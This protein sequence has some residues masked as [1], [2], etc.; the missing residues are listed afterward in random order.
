M[1][2][3]SI[4]DR[5]KSIFLDYID[6]YD[7]G[8]VIA[9]LPT[10]IGKTYS[11]CQTIADYVLNIIRQREKTDEEVHA[12]KIVWVTTLIKILPEEDL[13]KA[14][15]KR[16]LSYDD[17]VIR[18]KS[19]VD[20]ITEAIN[21]W[22]ELKNEIPE[23]V[24]H[25][26]EVRDITSLVREI[27][28]L[29]DKSSTEARQLLIHKQNELANSESSFRG[30]IHNHLAKV[31][32]AN[33]ISIED[34]VYEHKEYDWVSKIYPHVRENNYIV[35]LMTDK[36]LVLS[37]NRIIRKIPYLSKEWLKNA[38]VFIDESDATKTDVT[39]TVVDNI[40]K[41]MEG[42]ETIDF[43]KLFLMVY[44]GLNQLDSFDSYLKSFVNNKTR[45]E[46]IQEAK[47]LLQKYKMQ[48]SFKSSEGQIDRKDFLY[49]CAEWKT[50]HKDRNGSS[51][52]AIPD[53]SSNRVCLNYGKKEDYQ[54][55]EH[56]SFLV[57]KMLNDIN[58]FLRKFV[59]YVNDCAINYQRKRNGSLEVG[60]SELSQEE[61]LKTILYKYNGLEGD[62]LEL[63]LFFYS[64]RDISMVA[65]KYNLPYSFY[66]YGATW[67]SLVN[68]TYHEADTIIQMGRITETAEN[69]MSFL[70]QNALVIAMSATAN[71][72]TI[73]GNY[74]LS[75]LEN[76]LKYEDEQGRFI[77]DFHNILIE[78]PDLGKAIKEEL[79]YRYN[80][81]HIEDEKQ[82]IRIEPPIILNHIYD[83]EGRDFEE[84]F[85][86]ILPDNLSPDSK[87][88]KKIG[89][90]I[91]EAV[92]K[93]PFMD[94]GQ[95]SYNYFLSRYLN[96]LRVMLS[97]AV[98][99]NHQSC[100]CVDMA[101][102][103]EDGSTLQKKTLEDL[104]SVVNKYCKKH[105]KDWSDENC[106]EKHD[107]NIH[108]FIINSRDFF[109]QKDE[110]NNKLKNGQRLFIVSTF[111][112]V[113]AGINLHHPICE[114][115][116]P[117][118]RR[119]DAHEKR[120]D[121]KKDIDELAILD[122]TN[123]VV[124]LTKWDEFGWKEQIKNIIQI[125]E[126]YENGF[127]TDKER[128]K[129]INA[130]FNAIDGYGLHWNKNII[131]A[132]RQEA[133][134][135]AYWLV[136]V[137][138]RTKRTLWRNHVQTIYIDEKVFHSFDL[139]YQ[140]QMKDFHSEELRVILDFRE[141]WEKE[142]ERT[143]VTP[144]RPDEQ[145]LLAQ[146]KSDR[147]RQEIHRMI[148]AIDLDAG[149]VRWRPKDATNWPIMRMKAAR[150][151]IVSDE[152]YKED[153]FYSDFYIDFPD[154]NKRSSYYY[155]QKNDYDS[156]YVG[157]DHSKD[158]FSKKMEKIFKDG[159]SPFDIREV[160]EERSRLPILMKYKG[161]KRYFEE[162]GIDTEWKPSV[163]IASPIIFQEMVLGEYGEVAGEYILKTAI[164]ASP[165]RIGA[166]PISILEVFDGVFEDYPDVYVD[167]KYYTYQQQFD[168][169]A[170]QENNNRNFDKI[171]KK[172]K[173]IKA[174]AVFIIGIIAPT[175]TRL[176]CHKED[177]NIF[178]VPALID[179]NGQPIIENIQ[180]I[181]N[182]LESL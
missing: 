90:I 32:K 87:Y 30:I 27:S 105:S 107:E 2:G 115:I 180:F 9:P 65:Q 154:G 63:L 151:P 39:D 176:L 149:V 147:A 179:Q 124:N 59:N 17:H 76:E 35:F 47:E 167:F 181:I 45:A 157:F 49:Y 163:H 81:Y 118:L 82:S 51:L 94:D 120:D 5:I 158:E 169:E 175:D 140:Q 116:R 138:G 69:I 78:H 55:T 53:Y 122:I 7:H 37:R 93:I 89:T 103:G 3:Q 125:E 108:L 164:P 132:T 170:R 91:R 74:N 61:C 13:R 19:N 48:L 43:K 11:A 143:V 144:E 36:K 56:N 50:I 15:S 96:I 110:Y 16:N 83:S 168:L 77:N 98:H 117:Y 100:L 166:M 18:V 10:S 20:C 24:R 148:S 84:L 8:L 121:S 41:T 177:D 52:F 182:K 38:I 106:E 33:K 99:R 161:M 22:D 26:K 34:L 137:D 129:Q 58:T 133:L 75:F 150:H 92:D 134:Q 97:F 146:M 113:G 135:A 126:C 66:R 64:Q 141:Q 68:G 79:R 159:F 21:R 102:P 119:L 67:Y 44:E 139:A 86:E 178:I 172:I 95:A 60:Q 131:K 57:R 128:T 88:I 29:K 171:R 54:E 127:I 174:K 71:C 130:G 42:S 40:G 28:S 136:Q 160:S 14:F 123:M 85:A 25:C 109:S 4:S 72:P 73:L 104:I 46:L 156:V 165:I 152:Q 6:K 62:Y 173:I 31:A 23:E 112:T 70:S 155:Y 153:R 111:A 162:K 1:E 114:W 80:K 142:M 101:L 145:Q 12:R